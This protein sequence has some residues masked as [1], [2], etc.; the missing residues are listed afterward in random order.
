MHQAAGPRGAV[1][2]PGVSMCP[3][4][5]TGSSHV[6]SCT[7]TP[8]SCA[9]GCRKPLSQRLIWSYSPWREP[10][11]RRWVRE[12]PHAWALSA[13]VTLRFIYLALLRTLGFADI[14]RPVRSGDGRRDLGPAPPSAVLQR[15]VKAPKLSPAD[16]AIL[17]ALARLLTHPARSQLRL[18]VSPRTVLRWHADKSKRRWHYP[19]GHR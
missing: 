3:L 8:C 5:V 15:H 12:H 19:A 18:I 16:R 2:R 4:K 9:S 14:A 1:A 10:V 6:T 17:S 13:P 11:V 7:S